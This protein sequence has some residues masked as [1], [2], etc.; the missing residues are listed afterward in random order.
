[1]PT[2]VTAALPRGTTLKGRKQNKHFVMFS[3]VI[4]ILETIMTSIRVYNVD[5][6]KILILMLIYQPHICGPRM[7]Q[8]LSQPKHGLMW[9]YSHLIEVQ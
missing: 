2:C 6:R 9:V 1:M 8:N 4:L 3:I 7:M 5:K